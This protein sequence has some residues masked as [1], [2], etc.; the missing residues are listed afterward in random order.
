MSNTCFGVLVASYVDSTSASMNEIGPMNSS[1]PGGIGVI[2]SRATDARVTDSKIHE[3][4]ANNNTTGLMVV[5][6][7]CLK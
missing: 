2:L 1:D 4:K 7:G 3:W 6:D 5:D